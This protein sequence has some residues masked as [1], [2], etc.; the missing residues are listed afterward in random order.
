MYMYMYTLCMRSMLKGHIHVSSLAVVLGGLK[1]HIA[2]IRRSRRLLLVACGT[3]YH[4]AVAVS[5]VY[6]YVHVHVWVFPSQAYT[7]QI[8]LK[9]VGWSWDMTVCKRSPLVEVLFLGH[10]F[11]FDALYSVYPSSLINKFRILKINTC[12]HVL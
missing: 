2:T 4:S 1:D 3:S 5:N 12:T 7:T 10:S 11:L 8:S 9:W 6:M